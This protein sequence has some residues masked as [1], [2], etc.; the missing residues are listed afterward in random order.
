MRPQPALSPSFL[1]LHTGEQHAPW[2]H[3]SGPAVHAAHGAALLDANALLDPG[4]L[5]DP[6][7]AEEAWVLLDAPALEDAAWLLAMS[8]DVEPPPCEELDSVPLV[9]PPVEEDDDDDVD[10]DDDEPSSPKS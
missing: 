7:A 2:K 3:T 4:A 6:A 9:A 1:P 10:D 5:V 8:R